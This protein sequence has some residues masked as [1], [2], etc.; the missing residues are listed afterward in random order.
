MPEFSP[1]LLKSAEVIMKSNSS[2]KG[3]KYMQSGAKRWLDT[4]VTFST[5]PAVLP[6]I[7]LFG[8]L[9]LRQDGHYPFFKITEINPY[10]G[11]QTTILKIRSMTTNAPLEEEDFIGDSGSYAQAKRLK[12]DPRV[13][14]LGHKLRRY[15]LDELPQLWQ[16]FHDRSSSLVGP[17]YFRSG[18]INSI[19]LEKD[20]PYAEWVER[21]KNG[22]IL[23]GLTGLAQILGRAL[24]SISDRLWL[25]LYYLDRM[26]FIADLKIVGLTTTAILSAKGS[27]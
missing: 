18:D 11:K 8:L 9:V 20:Q 13:T 15:S 23:F 25:D 7:G 26:S 24:L 19:S 22:Q 2:L 16:I 10:T 4:V 27:K 14:P 17:R 5:L 12:H 6:A 3:L 1:S 21:Y